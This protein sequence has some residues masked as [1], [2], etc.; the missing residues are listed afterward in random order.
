MV[1]R[2]GPRYRALAP[3]LRGHGRRGALRP[4][5]FG[6]VVA[7]L[8]ALAPTRTT[9]VGYSQGG[10]VALHLALA[11]PARFSR[12]VLVATTAGLDD[13]EERAARRAADAALA[14]RMLASDPG[15]WIADW[16]EQPVFAGTPPHLRTAWA[17]DLGR[18]RPEDLG[19][20][21]RGLGT[22]AMEPVWDRL[23]ELT[24][25]V[26]VVVGE[27]DA[28]YA[29]L[30]RRLAEALPHATLHVLPGVGHG[31]PREDPSGLSSVL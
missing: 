27:R 31:V 18:S 17:R 3:D 13:P 7:D 10:R 26:D 4:V 25:P 16:Q 11:D 12:L 21:L 15:S 6:A 14:Q 23:G 19:E 22:G 8:L 9:L 28:K 5:A 30:G 29:T 20:V 2:L 24:M 1:E